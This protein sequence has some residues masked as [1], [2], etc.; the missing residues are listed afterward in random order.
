[1]TYPSSSA[2]IAGQATEAAQYNQLRSDALCFGTDPASSGTLRDLLWQQ[3]GMIRFSRASKTMIRLEASSAS[4]CAVMIGGRIFSVTSDL[5]VS[6]SAEAFPQP[7]RY[8]LYAVGGSGAAFILQAGN[9]NV[10]ASG[11]RIGTFLWSGSGVIPESIREISQWE[12]LQKVIDP[13]ICQGRL[14]L[15][16]GEPVPETDITLASALYFVPYR[17]NAAALYVGGTWDLFR[18]SELSLSLSGLIREIPYDIFL[19]ADENGLHLSALSWGTG[20]VRPAG[21]LARVDGVRVSGG[22]SSRRYLGTIAL[23]AA[24]YGEDSCRGRLVWNENHRLPRPLLSRLVTTKTQGAAHANSWAP[25]FD[26]DAPKVRLLVPASDCD[27]SLD[28]VGI[29]SPISENDRGYLRTA[30]VGICRDMM[31]ESPYT[32][33]EN[34]AAVFTHSYGN[35]PVTVNLRNRDSSFQGYHS[36]TLAFWSNYSF[37]PTGTGFTSVMGETPGLSGVIMG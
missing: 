9:S 16:P 19:E 11:I 21:M 35:G 13:Q 14:T 15:V 10:P 33:N 36:Y 30:A 8:Y 1:M 32:G 26:E 34:A 6:L 12:L 37:F 5:T 23:N 7:G 27:F 22:N 29:S 24:G 3:T 18:F 4:P 28:G 20:A 31:T 2:V 17:G 25:Y